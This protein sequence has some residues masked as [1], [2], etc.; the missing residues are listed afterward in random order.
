MFVL[1]RR[2][3]TITAKRRVLEMGL[4]L[5]NSAESTSE[6]LSVGVKGLLYSVNSSGRRCKF[7]ILPFQFTI[8]F[9]VK[10]KNQ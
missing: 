2:R 10:R 5:Q 4:R 1:Y 8:N 6:C 9:E 7:S 3:D